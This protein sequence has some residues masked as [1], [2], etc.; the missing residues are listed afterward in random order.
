MSG[1]SANDA[2]SGGSKAAD[3][4]GAGAMSAQCTQECCADADCRARATCTQ[5][6]CS[7]G[8]AQHVCGDACVDSRDVATCG[9][10]CEACPV[11]RGGSAS[12]D[13]T[14]CPSGMRLC[15]GTCIGATMPCDGMCPD[16]THA[17]SNNRVA[18]TSVTACG[19]SC[20]PCAAPD[21][22]IATCDGSKC[23]FTCDSTHK[24][25]GDGF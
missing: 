14:S 20:S 5:G 2:G 7:C 6:K 9:Q 25:R 16:G 17:C 3:S 13:G 12:S 18:N 19:A 8:S 23:E 11:P 10:S 24:R 21:H 4:A 15:A 22:A 1:D